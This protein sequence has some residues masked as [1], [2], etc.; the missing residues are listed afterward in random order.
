AELAGSRNIGVL[1]SSILPVYNYTPQSQEFFASRPMERILALNQWMKDYCAA[2]KLIYLDYFSA[3]VD[4]KGML[5]RDLAEDGLHPNKAGYAIMAPVA[6]A[7]IERA[8]SSR[9]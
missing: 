3:V 7:A 8:L 2:N 4:E 5:K 1:F 6:Q 9:P